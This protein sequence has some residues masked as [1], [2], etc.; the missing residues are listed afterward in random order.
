M[1]LPNNVHLDMLD[2]EDKEIMLDDDD[3]GD[4]EIKQIT[5][6]GI[7]PFSVF[8]KRV[9]FLLGKESFE[10]KFGDSWSDFSGKIEDG[11]TIEQGAA[12][13]FYEETAGCVML[14]EQARRKLE[15]GDYLLSSDLH[16][17]ESTSFR[18]YLLLVP[19]KDYP[20][21]F[22]RTKSF[23]QHPE[24]HGD[25][26]I[27]EKSQ[28]QWFPYEEFCEAIFDRWDHSRYRRKPRFRTRFAENMRRIMRRINLREHCL[29]A[30]ASNGSSVHRRVTTS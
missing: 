9:Y 24:V 29:E 16:P 28:L 22:R 13:E 4:E 25:V 8:K 26:S 23:I 21:M 27:I 6:A 11:E 2:E 5:S 20:L 17:R 30:Y 7:L 18:T 14:L 19:Y 3:D 10:P 12:R 15:V 1:S